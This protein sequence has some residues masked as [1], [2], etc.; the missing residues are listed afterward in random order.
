MASFSLLPCSPG[1]R[2]FLFSA[3]NSC[4]SRS[5]SDNSLIA[6]VLVIYAA[7]PLIIKLGDLKNTR[8]LFHNFCEP[9][10]R[11]W[12]DGCLC[13]L[14]QGATVLLAG[15]QPHF[16]A[17]LQKNLLLVVDRI[18]FFIG[19]WIES[20]SSSLAVGLRPLQLLAAWI[21]PTRPS[22]SSKCKLRRQ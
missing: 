12:T 7:Q 1:A 17:S 21:S 11:T 9:A 10:V 22:V 6:T 20:L 3:V 15:L 5:I 4:S 14:T 19:C 18:W 16:K 8:V 2:L 13:D